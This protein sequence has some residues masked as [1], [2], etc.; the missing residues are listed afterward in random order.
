MHPVS[1]SSRRRQATLTHA[2]KDLP[3]GPNPD[4]DPSALE[5][6]MVAMEKAL[7]HALRVGHGDMWGL[8]CKLAGAAHQ[9]QP[10]PYI[11][12]LQEVAGLGQAIQ[13]ELAQVWIVYCLL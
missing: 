7:V 2:A 6:D 4:E 8:A 12:A 9:P 1:P 13:D 11:E 10:S 5:T 3:N